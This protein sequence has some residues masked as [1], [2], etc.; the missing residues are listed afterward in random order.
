[1]VLEPLFWGGC[2]P[3]DFFTPALFQVRTN[4]C[5]NFPAPDAGYGRQLRQTDCHPV[6]S[7]SSSATN[8][9]RLV[10]TPRVLSVKDPG[11]KN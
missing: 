4:G 11:D 10:V 7:A 6:H 3:L 5:G 1:M 9:A 2:L 8:A